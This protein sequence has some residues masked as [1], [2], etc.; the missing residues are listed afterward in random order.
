VIPDG[1]DKPAHPFILGAELE[2]QRDPSFQTRLRRTIQI[3]PIP[4]AH[5]IEAGLHHGS[6]AGFVPRKL[7]TSDGKQ[8]P[9]V[10]AQIPILGRQKSRRQQNKG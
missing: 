5:Q 2:G 3:G 6:Q 7:V 8:D 10:V 1:T 9:A 4:A